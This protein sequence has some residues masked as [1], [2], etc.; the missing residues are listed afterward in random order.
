MNTR[1]TIEQLEK[2]KTHELADLLA[3]VV[4]L[5]RRLPD[6]EWQALQPL[7]EI[8]PA[9]PTPQTMAVS[10]PAQLVSAAE[11]KRMKV[12][13]IRKIAED[14]NIIFTKKTKKEELINKIIAWQGS[15]GHS[16]QYNI[17]HL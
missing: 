16:E 17:L 12:D 7:H 10:T 3:N 5:L 14:L 11:L 4:M 13:E 6:V 15:E 9:T 1:I 2:M 8:V